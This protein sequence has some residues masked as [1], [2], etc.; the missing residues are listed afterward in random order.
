MPSGQYKGILPMSTTHAV[1]T[2]RFSQ[3]V[4]SALGVRE[5]DTKFQN[6]IEKALKAQERVHYELEAAGISIPTKELEMA[7]FLQVAH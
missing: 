3:E 4:I 1:L 7:S 6:A 2:E 5:E